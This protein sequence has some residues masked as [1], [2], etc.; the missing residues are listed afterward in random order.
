M[1]I[2]NTKKGVINM[3][4]KDRKWNHIKCSVKNKKQAEK[5]QKAIV[6]KRT[7]TT[8]IKLTNMINSNLISVST[9]NTNIYMHQLKDC[10]SI[11]NL[12]VP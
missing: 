4:R 10:Q 12:P 11:L 8:N 2:A 5:E 6:G 9:L 3:L 1:H 7:K